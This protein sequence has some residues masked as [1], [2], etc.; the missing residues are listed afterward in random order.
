MAAVIQRGPSAMKPSTGCPRLTNWPG[1]SRRLVMAPAPG[2]TTAVCASSSVACST[3][4]MACMTCGC[5]AMPSPS[6]IRA[7][8]ASARARSISARVR[9]MSLRARMAEVSDSARLAERSSTILPSCWLVAS[10]TRW[11][12]SCAAA[13]RTSAALESTPCWATARLAWAARRAISNGR[14]SSRN[15][16]WPARTGWLSR[17]STAITGPLTSGAICTRKVCTVAWEE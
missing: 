16:T 6:R 13:T 11:R 14:R 9:A 15:N 2:A 3:A 7:R 8:S 4:A 10:S 1:A 5:P 12:R 17:T